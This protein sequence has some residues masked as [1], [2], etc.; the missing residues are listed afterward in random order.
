MISIIITAFKEPQ[1]GR[2]IESF[3]N[4][5]IKGKCELIVSAPDEETQSIVKKY[6]KVILFK[7]PGKGKALALNL[8][9]KKAKGEKI[10]LT[11]G[12]VYVSKNSVNEL[13]KEFENSAIGCVAGRPVPLEDKTTKYGYWANFLFDSAHRLRKKLLIKEK[14]FQSSGYLY[15]IKSGIVKE[16]PFDTADDAIIPHIISN[17]GYKT[18]Y[19][20][21]ALVFVKNV[22]NWKDW[23]SQKLRCARAHENL[24]K[25]VDLSK[26]KRTKTF[27]N[28][29]RG[30]LYLFSY[31]QTIKELLWT[32]ELIFARLYLWGLVFFEV[33]V[34]KKYHEDNWKRVESA[35]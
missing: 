20:E 2:A 29:S 28:E 15:M 35:R 25:Y 33:Y 14:F 1:V 9:F 11:D 7:D 13:L 21:K 3:L 12:D 16:I 10:I 23:I 17:K 27:G 6:K 34:K 22:D 30:I 19:A 26:N 8:L 24:G 5:N 18:A 31:P 4:Q 32:F